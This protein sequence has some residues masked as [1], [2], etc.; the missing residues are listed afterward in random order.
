MEKL[1]P[2]KGINQT[3]K[4]KSNFVLIVLFAL[5]LIAYLFFLNG[6]HKFKTLP[7]V[8]ESIG[9]IENFKRLEDNATLQLKDSLTIITF[10]GKNPYQRIGYISNINEKVYRKFHEFENFQMISIIDT[11]GTG[12]MKDV[13]YQLKTNTDLTDWHFLT[14]NDQSINDFFNSL[15]TDLEL[16]SDLSSDYAFMVDKKA[17]LRGRPG[18]DEEDEVIGY[19]TSS[20]AAI[21]KTMVDDIR[22]FMAEYRMA[23]KKN[24]SEKIKKDE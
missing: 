1:P 21:N 13:Y 18:N 15:G 24:R 6:E 10:L 17:R 12:D 14:G 3:N 4:A 2:A 19:D 11:S 20:L 16:N 8:K 22:V 7:V 9:S 23:F 5:P